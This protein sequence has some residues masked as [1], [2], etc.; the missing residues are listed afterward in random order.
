MTSTIDRREVGEGTQN[1]TYVLNP[2]ALRRPDAS[3]EFPIIR[4][5]GIDKLAELSAGETLV[6]PLDA[7]LPPPHLAVPT[8]YAPSS[9][10]A[11]PRWYRSRHRRASL[12]SWPHVLIGV[13]IIGALAL[14]WSSGFV[15]AMVLSGVL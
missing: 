2:P 10:R 14:S 8:V 4:P 5:V 11:R 7:E 6:L 12:W 9:H 3:G 13:G 1:L 15:S